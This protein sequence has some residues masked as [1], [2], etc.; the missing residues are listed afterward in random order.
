MKKFGLALG[1]GAAK[2]FAHLG[3]LQV[4]EEHNLIPDYIA[5]GS[6]GSL[7]GGVYALNQDI[8]QVAELVDSYR[9]SDLFVI[10]VATALLK[11]G[12]GK[13]RQFARKMS[14]VTEHKK[15]EDCKIPFC[16]NAIDLNS[17]EQVVLDS[18]ELWMAIRAS[19]SIPG[20]L[21]PVIIDNKVLVDGGLLNRVPTD[22]V[23]SRGAE[24]V[25]GID[26]LGDFLPEWKPKSF[27]SVTTR[28]FAVVDKITFH[29]HP[30]D[31]D[32]MLTPDHPCVDPMSF[33]CANKKTSIAAGRKVMEDNIDRLI[34][35]LEA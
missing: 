35:L 17:G 1:V 10:D 8:C 25:L 18:G 9:K 3:V 20:V 23:R 21:P 13:D 5:G 34:Q 4:L 6:M 19:C 24:V 29:A 28:A 22:L 33:N 2:G 27:I 30:V 14:K 15:I 12:V 31:Y 11:S 16:C 7:I 32:M 26:C